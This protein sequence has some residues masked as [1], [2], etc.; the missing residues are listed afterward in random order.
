MASNA[1]SSAKNIGYIAGDLASPCPTPS[2]LDS[3]I[4]PLILRMLRVLVML[5]LIILI[6]LKLSH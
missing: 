1:N 5:V 6:Q 3:T 2:L 4:P